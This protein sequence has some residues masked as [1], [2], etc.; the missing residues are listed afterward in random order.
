MTSSS[1]SSSRE[2]SPAPLIAF[3]VSLHHLLPWSESSRI[4]SFTTGFSQELQETLNLTSF[5]WPCSAAFCFNLLKMSLVSVELMSNPE[6]L[7]LEVWYHWQNPSVVNKFNVNYGIQNWASV[8]RRWSASWLW[9]HLLDSLW[10]P[11]EGWH[12]KFKVGHIW[13]GD[14]SGWGC[15]APDN[16][17][18]RT[19]I[20]SKMAGCSPVT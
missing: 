6:G 1:F 4:W 2:A 20:L 11:G 9:L 8:Q 16:K 13:T 7:E 5:P 15:T 19:G 17:Y 3:G 18:L 14:R 12:S 10:M